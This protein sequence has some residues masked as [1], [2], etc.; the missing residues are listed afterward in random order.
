MKMFV[1]AAAN[2]ARDLTICAELAE[3][4]LATAC[5]QEALTILGAGEKLAVESSETIVS[6]FRK[7]VSTTPNSFAL[8]YAEVLA[9]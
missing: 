9:G 5:E 2:V 4:S 6:M 8:V 7:R 1:N 3:I